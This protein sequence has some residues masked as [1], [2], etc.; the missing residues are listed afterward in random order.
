MRKETFEFLNSLYSWIKILSYLV[1]LKC[2]AHN[3]MTRNKKKN[4]HQT[5][6]RFQYPFSSIDMHILEENHKII[7]FS[8]RNF[9]KYLCKTFLLYTIK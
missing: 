6:L 9:Q 4:K 7:R 8:I 5:F 1:P 2:Y 3:E